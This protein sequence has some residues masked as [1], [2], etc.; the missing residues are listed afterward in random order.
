MPPSTL[1]KT[2][3]DVFNTANPI[4]LQSGDPRYVDCTAVRG[5]EDAVTRI[6]RRPRNC[7][8]GIAAAANP[9]SC[10]ACRSG[11]RMRAMP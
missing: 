4:P 3:K 8:R 10:S 6:S 7:S 5:N 11:W 9:R 1:A 2:L